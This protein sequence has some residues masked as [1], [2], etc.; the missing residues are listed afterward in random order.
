MS[1]PMFRALVVLFGLQVLVAVSALM[2][3]PTAYAANITVNTVADNATGKDGK[4]TLREAI[5]NANT[6][7]DTTN[8]DCAMGTGNDTIGFRVYG[9]IA[10]NSALPTLTT[11]MSL[12]SANQ[13]VTLDAG[14]DYQILR[15]K[16]SGTTVN[17]TGLIFYR[18]Y[19]DAS[20]GGGGAITNMAV[21][22]MDGAVFL[23]NDGNPCVGGGA[24]NNKGTLN[25]KDT[26][27]SNNSGGNAA[28]GAIYNSGTA[29]ITGGGFVSNYAYDGGAIYNGLQG[30]MTLNGVVFQQN[31]PANY[32]GAIMN[33]DATLNVNG[34]TFQ[35]NKT[36]LEG[37]GGAIA[38]MEDS[39]A[40]ISTSTFTKNYAKR[41]GGIYNDTST[42]RVTATTLV[43]NNGWG[44]GGG[45]YNVA[46]P[47]TVTN[48]TL[49]ANWTN[50]QYGGAMYTENGLLYV[51]NSTL[52][53]NSCTCSL[54]GAGGIDIEGTTVTLLNTINVN[55]DEFYDYP[56]CDLA[57]GTLT[58][59]SYNLAADNSCD[60]ATQVTQ[61][62]LNVG[63]L[64]NNGGPTQTI[65]PQ[66]GSKARDAGDNT[67][68]QAAIGEPTYGAGK[69]D[70]RGVPRPQSGCDV[71]AYEVR[72]K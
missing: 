8:G 52:Y 47:L 60:Q 25:L 31:G 71:G 43:K 51:V 36:Y 18:G 17:V 4:C 3:V 7:R 45:I 66:A 14:N 44:A 68:C 62:Q 48:S 32:G 9:S 30:T 16:G 72:V 5:N 64:A 39:T 10:L 58:V 26:T 55:D 54:G 49:T 37:Y 33:E 57:S 28:G 41:G 67:V 12:V 70:Q 35:S 15:I 13:E 46:A 2:L 38:N 19:C 56:D 22:N 61:A 65:K 40:N 24:I 6:D 20:K 29:T 59:N 11:S 23:Y 34:S 1:I 21:L 42:M 53:L 63:D 27:F 50:G 69:V